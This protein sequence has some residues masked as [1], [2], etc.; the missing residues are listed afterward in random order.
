MAAAPQAGGAPL[1]ETLAGGGCGVRRALRC[2]GRGAA[3][4]RWSA[5]RGGSIRSVEW[6]RSLQ[7]HGTVIACHSP[8]I[9]T[10]QE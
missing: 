10:E 5:L 2:R 9:W 8:A 4:G 7:A 6:S 3:K 1:A